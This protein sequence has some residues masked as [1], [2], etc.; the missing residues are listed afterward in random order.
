MRTHTRYILFFFLDT[1]WSYPYQP[2]I[3]PGA[4]NLLL[5]PIWGY[6][7]A[8]PNKSVYLAT[9]DVKYWDE[10]TK[11]VERRGT[12]MSKLLGSLLRTYVEDNRSSVEKGMGLPVGFKV[13]EA[14]RD[15]ELT[16]REAAAADAR[17][18]LMGVLARYRD[19]LTETKAES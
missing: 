13:P 16:A 1:A 6:Y 11:I 18:Y 19:A 9:G 12:S 5:W 17:D 3:T 10:A 2:P 4:S 7:A 14:Y 8:M 15:P